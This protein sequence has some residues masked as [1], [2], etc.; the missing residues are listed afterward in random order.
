MANSVFNIAAT[1]IGTS[2]SQSAVIRKLAEYGSKIEAPSQI[3]SFS[4]GK[5][6][7]TG[8]SLGSVQL[9][10]REQRF[11]IE[12]WIRLNTKGGTLE[13]KVRGW[14]FN[15]P[16]PGLDPPEIIDWWFAHV[17]KG[18]YSQ[19]R[20]LDD[21]ERILRLNKDRAKKN[22]LGRFKELRARKRYLLRLGH[23]A[24]TSVP[25]TPNMGYEQYKTQMAPLVPLT[26]ENKGQ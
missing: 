20:Q 7:E 22:T 1:N 26:E 5:H 2:E 24:T 6:S 17:A 10:T 25:M 18:G 23:K 21:I 19:T 15:S 12:E 13:K 11:F 9:N 16:P 4:V 14:K 3:K 8:K